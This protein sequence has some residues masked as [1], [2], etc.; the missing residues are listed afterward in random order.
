[1]NTR[2]LNHP[3]AGRCCGIR[4]SILLVGLLPV[5]VPARSDAYQPL[6]TPRVLQRPLD[7]TGPMLPVFEAWLAATVCADPRV[8][9]RA[10][11]SRRTC[12]RALRRPVSRCT[13]RLRRRL[14]RH[15][16]REIDGRMKYGEFIAAYQG[17]LRD[18]FKA[19]RAGR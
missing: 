1:M 12:V 4:L 5:F 18:E 2:N 11:G 19:R 9:S 6:P 17:C 15:D 3:R 8:R 10:G 13:D 7:D 14:P 16:S